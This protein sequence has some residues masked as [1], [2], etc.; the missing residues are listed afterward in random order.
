MLFSGINWFP[1]S[2]GSQAYW[3]VST[4]LDVRYLLPLRGKLLP[5]LQAG[6]GIYY[7]DSG[8]IN[9]GVN[10][11]LGMSY[12]LGSRLSL[13]LGADYHVIMDPVIQFMSVHGGVVFKF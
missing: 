4:N 12:K 11:G 2:S 8:S 7:D 5:Y 1:A 10:S 13:E 9:Y 6:P 3:N